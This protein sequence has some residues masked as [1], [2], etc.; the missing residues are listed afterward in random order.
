MPSILVVDDSTIVRTQVRQSLEDAGY[1]VTE[2]IHAPRW[3]HFQGRTGSNYP[4]KETNDLIVES[5]VGPGVVE[6][7]S[8]RGHPAR[9][10]GAWGG[11]GSAGAIRVG[12][13]GAL[14]A[15]SDPRRDGQAL[16]F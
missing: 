11:R 7:L 8:R 15:A 14:M 4:H 16:V 9:A 2:A 1:T 10:V 5:R 6:D 13:S 3:T 12:E